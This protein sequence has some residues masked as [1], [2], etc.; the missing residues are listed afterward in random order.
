MKFGILILV[1]LVVIH[2]TAGQTL[3]RRI[4]APT[5]AFKQLFIEFFIH[6]PRISYFVANRSF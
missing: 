3:Y 2:R 5:D 6:L 1:S 4:E